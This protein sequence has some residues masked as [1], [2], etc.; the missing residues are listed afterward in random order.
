MFASVR[1]CRV[2]KINNNGCCCGEQEKKKTILSAAVNSHGTF[3]LYAVAREIVVCNIARFKVLK[4]C[5]WIVDNACKSCA[6]ML[7]AKGAILRLIR[8]ETMSK[9]AALYIFKNSIFRL[10]TLL[11]IPGAS[12]R[13]FS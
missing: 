7:L 11:H 13:N 8:V 1:I 6:V 5:I 10:Y 12:F 9:L 4:M 3:A 2:K